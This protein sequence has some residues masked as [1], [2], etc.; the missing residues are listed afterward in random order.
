M[1]P[2]PE[3]EGFAEVVEFRQRLEPETP[4]ETSTPNIPVMERAMRLLARRALSMGE[5]EVALRKEHYDETEID[6][7]IR[8]CV[9]RYYLDDHALAERL[10]EKAMQRKKLGRSAL[11]RELKLRLI[12]DP[13]ID[14]VMH[15]TSEDDERERMRE[16]AVERA[17]KL[18]TLDRQTAERRLVAFLSRRGF[19]GAHLHTIVREALD[20]VSAH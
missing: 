15:E 2:Q 9:D 17:R 6:E 20:E 8:E 16:A 3:R 4:V 10:L 5:L 7:T 18:T 19:G 14:V 11:R 13:I 1:S 12:A